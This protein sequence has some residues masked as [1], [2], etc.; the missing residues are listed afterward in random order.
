MTPLQLHVA[1]INHRHFLLIPGS[2]GASKYPDGKRLAS[3][4]RT[5]LW[6]WS[7]S[8]SSLPSGGSVG[9]DKVI[10][11]NTLIGR[12]SIHCRADKTLF[13]ALG[14]LHSLF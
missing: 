12:S 13:S 4:Q 3:Y 10:L 6:R 14:R 5:L 8:S 9:R 1:N 2:D 7:P 11:P